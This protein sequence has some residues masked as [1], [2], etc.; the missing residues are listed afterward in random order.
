MFERMAEAEEEEEQRAFGP[1]TK[2][3]SAGRGDEHQRVDLEALELQILDGLAD[4]EPATEAISGNIECE[5]HP[6]RR[7]GELLDRKAD[8]EDETA[9]QREDQLGPLAEDAAMIMAMVVAILARMAM[10]VIWPM[11]VIRTMVMAIIAMLVGGLCR[12]SRGDGSRFLSDAHIRECLSDHFDGGLRALELGAQRTGGAD[13]GLDHARHFA[14]LQSDRPR[15]TGVADAFEVIPEEMLILAGELGTG[16]ARELPH[17]FERENIR[18][19]M[20]AELWRRT[21]A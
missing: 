9:Q 14:K 12:G 8:A 20:D 5:R 4:S 11:R 7:R 1:R 17:A 13:F 15:A 6:L 16:A 19:V 21:V 2:R 3:G 18:T 10:F